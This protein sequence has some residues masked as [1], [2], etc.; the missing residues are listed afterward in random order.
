MNN[1]NIKNILEN[2][3]ILDTNEVKTSHILSNITY[4]EVLILSDESNSLKITTLEND[5]VNLDSSEWIQASSNNSEGFAIYS[6][7]I[8]ESVKLFI[9]ETRVETI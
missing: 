2:V 8:D 5:V 3:S 9:D 4:D 1:D 7:L 6:S